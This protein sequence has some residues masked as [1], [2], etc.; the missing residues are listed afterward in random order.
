MEA[1]D[2]EIKAVFGLLYPAGMFRANHKNL[3]DFWRNR[4]IF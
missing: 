2:V 4:Y 1:N 3:E